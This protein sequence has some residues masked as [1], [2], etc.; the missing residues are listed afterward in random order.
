MPNDEIPARDSQIAVVSRGYS[1]NDDGW[2]LTVLGDYISN[3]IIFLPRFGDTR[4][5]HTIYSILF[6]VFIILIIVTAFI[7]VALTYFQLAAEDHAWWW[8]SVFCGGSTGIFIL[9][10]CFYYYEARSDMSGFMQTSFF[11]G[12]MSIICVT[13][14]S[15]VRERWI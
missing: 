8:R 3:F 13:G 11:F 9:G 6:I 12:Y 2:F 1:A 15:D 10:Y 7:C 5:V 4:L 14:S